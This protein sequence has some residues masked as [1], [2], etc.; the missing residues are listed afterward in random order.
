[1]KATVFGAGGFIGA[2]LVEHLRQE[3]WEVLALRRGDDHWQGVDLGHVFYC[4]GLTADFRT[5]P[6]ETI[7]AHVGFAAELLRRAQFA[8]FLY[9]SS[10]RVYAGAPE[11]R[12]TTPLTVDPNDPGD[13]YNL[14]K[15]LGEA[16]C[17]A[18]DRPEVRIARL[19]NVFGSGM[20]A[21]NFLMAVVREA[22]RT[23]RIA[24]RQALDSE[25]DY[26]AV[27]DVAAALVRISVAGGH[28]LYNLA[29]GSNTTHAKLIEALTSLTGCTVAVAPGSAAA[30]F[31]PIATERLQSL[32]F[33]PTRSVLRALPELI[34]AAA[35]TS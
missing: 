30:R 9:L 17:L 4:V 3:G 6:F 26:V 13:L 12:E 16:A 8:S 2:R 15:L 33:R 11:G 24:L 20:A 22:V 29:G 10:T 19:S 5:R 31:P 35:A 7:E 34:A 32:G 27:E 25:K 1:M 28:R 18:V 23:G 14:S 21:D